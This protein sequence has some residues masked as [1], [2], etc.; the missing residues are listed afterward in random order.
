[1]IDLTGKT[2]VIT[3]ASR[4]IGKAT[5]MHL[6]GLGATV[7]LTARNA[8]QISDIASEINES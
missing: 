3:G 5:A 7:V 1:M 2:A 8:S 4:G 6:A